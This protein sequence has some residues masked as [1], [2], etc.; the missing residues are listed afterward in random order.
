[1]W[2]SIAS[3]LASEFS[4]LT[5]PVALTQVITRIVLATAAAAARGS[6]RT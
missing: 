3:T 1:M 6:A 2:D 4:D 5:D